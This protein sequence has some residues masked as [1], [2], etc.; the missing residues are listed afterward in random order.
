MPDTGFVTDYLVSYFGDYVD[1]TFTARMEGDL[2]EVLAALRAAR[3]AEQV[4][5]LEAGG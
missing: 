3:A 4:A 2:D 1:L 5:A